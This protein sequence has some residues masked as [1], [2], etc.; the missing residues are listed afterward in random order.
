MVAI[1]DVFVDPFPIF[2]CQ[3]LPAGKPHFRVFFEDIEIGGRKVWAASRAK[4][5][6]FQM[7]ELF[8]LDCLRISLEL[9]SGADQGFER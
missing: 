5:I 1:R 8:C 7:P 3:E 6:G 4:A 2:L 9:G